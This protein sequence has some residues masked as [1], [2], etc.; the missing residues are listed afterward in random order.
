MAKVRRSLTES[1]TTLGFVQQSG[2]VYGALVCGTNVQQL[3]AKIKRHADR[4]FAP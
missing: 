3:L 1:V 2:A 4:I